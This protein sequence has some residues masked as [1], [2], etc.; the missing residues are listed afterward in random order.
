MC[1]FGDGDSTLKILKQI[2]DDVIY[3]R[4]WIAAYNE[5]RTI[6]ILQVN[7]PSLVRRFPESVADWE[8]DLPELFGTT[9]TPREIQVA[10]R[11]VRGLI[12]KE[13]AAELG[14]TPAAVRS[15]ERNILIKLGLDS[16]HD[17]LKACT[18]RWHARFQSVPASADQRHDGDL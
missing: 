17:L 18:E 12:S 5:A 1:P 6:P 13:T 15:H 4:E 2:H 11:R 8:R 14:I 16:V 9:L 7:N 3:I 10:A